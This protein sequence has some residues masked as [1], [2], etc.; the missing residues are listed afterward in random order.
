M[1]F[2]RRP[3]TDGRTK[4]LWCARGQR[5]TPFKESSLGGKSSQWCRNCPEARA[6][7]SFPLLG[8]IHQYKFIVDDQWRFSPDQPSLETKLL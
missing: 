3:S 2:W 8:G 7:S 5:L 4:S 6:L 1:C